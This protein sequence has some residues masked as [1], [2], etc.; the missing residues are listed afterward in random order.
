MATTA[1]A[2][3]QEQADGSDYS[4]DDFLVMSDD[5]A[6]TGEVGQGVGEE[7]RLSTDSARVRFLRTLMSQSGQHFVWALQRIA[8]LCNLTGSE[9][10]SFKDELGRQGVIEMMTTAVRTADSRTLRLELFNAL[11]RSIFDH[12]DNAALATAQG[13]LEATAQALCASE[14]SR[15]EELS[16]FQL[17]CAN[18]VCGMI[19]TE[20]QCVLDSGIIPVLIRFAGGL[21]GTTD[22]GREI[23]IAAL[24]NLSNAQA[25]SQGLIVGG[26][27]EVLSAGLHTVA[28]DAEEPTVSYMQALSA[29]V[30]TVG[31][32]ALMG[33]MGSR[34]NNAQR[35][36]HA[37]NKDVHGRETEE[38]GS[39]FH[40]CGCRSSSSFDQAKMLGLVVDRRSARWLLDY[41]RASSANRPYPPSSSIYG[42]AWKVAQSVACMANGSAQNRRVLQQEGVWIQVS[43]CACACA[44][45]IE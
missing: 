45:A 1:W 31:R 42:T 18:N 36:N 20:H 3:G 22:T 35:G 13:L 16:E 44:R 25:L 5:E 34:F 24:A 10:R 23:A 41:L 27:V 30:K 17:C 21:A 6:E 9:G 39:V 26:A 43:V 33:G 4:D 11:S 40:V 38:E 29:V 19:L 12:R 15:D 2:I 37:Q 28:D 14:S 8:N 7:A 32:S